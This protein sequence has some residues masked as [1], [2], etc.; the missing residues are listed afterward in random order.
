MK[1]VETPI[2]DLL[3][4]EPSVFDDDRGYFYESFNKERFLKNGLEYDFVQDNQSF[5]SY[6]TIRGLHLQVGEFAQAKLV[7]CPVGKV[8]DVAVDLRVGSETFGQSFSIELSEENHRQLLIPRSFAHGFS[9]LSE[10]ALFQYKC[11]NFYNKESERGIIYSDSTLSID[12]QVEVDKISL[13]EK[14]K[15]L[16]TYNEYCERL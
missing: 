5:S 8:L 12:W 2:K 13:S 7:R 15:L 14:D 9:V 10:N 1:I 11:D 16:P 3:I 6:G 4:I